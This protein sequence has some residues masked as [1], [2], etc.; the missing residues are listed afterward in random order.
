MSRN[1]AIVPA[2][3]EAGAIATTIAALRQWASDFDVVVI[4]DGSSDATAARARAAGATVLRMPFNLGIGGAMQSGYIYAREQGY[5][6]AVQVDGDGQ[7]DPRH[8]HSLLARLREDPELNMV[9]GSRFLDDA[10]EGYRS[11]AAR[12]IGIRVFSTV[13][14]RIT[15]QRVTDPTSGFRMTD[16]R[17]IELF[18]RDYPHDYPEVEAILLMHAH[19]LRSCEIPVV[20]RPRLTGRSAI[21]STQSIYYMVKVLLALF[22]AL[23]RARPTSEAVEAVETV[24]TANAVAETEDA[25]AGA[26]A[27]PD[28]AAEGVG[29][30]G[31]GHG[32]E[33]AE[34]PDAV[35]EAPDAV[36]EGGR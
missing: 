15:G 4:D 20:M 1:L 25:A 10:G 31:R 19:R 35:A 13:V 33:L 8:I 11:S 16:R 3:N 5:D 22:V 27:G 21:S 18:A 6:V 32:G 24:E 14:S 29:A 2:Y 23:F 26:A 30:T 28:A 36:A 12:R 17:G 34:A 7:H 9:T